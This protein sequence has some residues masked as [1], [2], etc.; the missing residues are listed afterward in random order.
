MF[1]GR[2]RNV[3]E[4]P[5]WLTQVVYKVTSYS[6]NETCLL[7][8]TPESFGGTITYHRIPPNTAV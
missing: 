8:P 2:H 7:V 3:T 5:P 4:R 1:I 6:Y